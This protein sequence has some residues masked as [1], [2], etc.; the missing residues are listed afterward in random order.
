MAYKYIKVINGGSC[1]LY[2]EDKDTWDGS[3]HELRIG[4]IYKVEDGYVY[5]ENGYF[6]PDPIFYADP[7]PLEVMRYIKCLK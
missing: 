6:N 4:D 7:T 1:A 5:T 2:K 3:R